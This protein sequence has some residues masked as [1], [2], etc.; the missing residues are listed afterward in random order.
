M[1]K[2]LANRLST[3]IHEVIRDDQAGFMPNKPTAINIRRL[4]L[5]LQLSLDATGSRVVLSLDAAK[6]FGS[7]KWEFLWAVLGKRGFG[8]QFI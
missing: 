8:P 6:A 1:A 4:Y 3:V 5:N 7:D 2:V